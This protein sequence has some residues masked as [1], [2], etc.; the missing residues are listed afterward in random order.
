MVTVGRLPGHGLRIQATG[1]VL[2]VVYTRAGKV[3]L[4]K[5]ADMPEFWQSITGAMR[6]AETDRA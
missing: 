5:R 3:L 1:V 4:L 2:V 6:W